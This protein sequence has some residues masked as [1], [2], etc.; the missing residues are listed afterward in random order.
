MVNER[1]TGRRGETPLLLR[2][3]GF[4]GLL[5]A[6]G[7]G[8]L[9]DLGQA[10]GETARPD[11]RAAVGA[12]GAD[13]FQRPRLGRPGLLLL[14][15]TTRSVAL[16]DAVA[17]ALGLARADHHLVVGRARAWIVAVDDDF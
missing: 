5:A 6:L 13:R 10:A 8:L 7:T 12:R 16:G 15:G 2:R 9:D 14:A 3:G 4:V 11:R 17:L 1:L